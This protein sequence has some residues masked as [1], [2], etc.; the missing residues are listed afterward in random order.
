MALVNRMRKQTA[1]YWEPTGKTDQNGRPLYKTPVELSP[2]NTS[3]VGVP[4]GVRWEE[5]QVEFKDLNGEDVVSNAKIYVGQELKVGGLLRKGT[6]ASVTWPNDPRR[7]KN[8]ETYEIRS[9]NEIP[10]IN[11]LNL[12]KTLRYVFV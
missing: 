5:R 11:A 6:L 4:N 9:Y 1:V 10:A 8:P 7:N 3:P 2:A 12:K